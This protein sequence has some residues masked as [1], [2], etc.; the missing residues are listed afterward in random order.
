MRPSGVRASRTRHDSVVR[1]PSPKMM[2][3]MVPDCV[4]RRVD[5]S[6]GLIWADNGTALMASP[7]ATSAVLNCMVQLP[8]KFTLLVRAPAMPECHFEVSDWHLC[9]STDESPDYA[10]PGVLSP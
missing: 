9:T 5:G 6:R 10:L 1:V 7:S 2:S 8:E 4:G 3:A